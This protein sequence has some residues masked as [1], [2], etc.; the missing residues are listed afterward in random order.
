MLGIP[1]TGAAAFDIEHFVPE[2]RLAC[3]HTI[4]ERFSLGYNVGIV[5][6]GS[7]T[8]YTGLYS[9]ALGV[10]LTEMF[11]AYAELYGD[12][13]AYVAPVHRVDAGTTYL[14]TPDLQLDLSAGY[15]LTTP[16]RSFLRDESEYYFAA[17]CS[18]RIRMWR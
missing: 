8:N 1:G 4:S 13:A 16:S 9:V 2:A 10:S 15:T 6:N 11:G 3:S 14:A 7:L 5:L 17:G 12:L 18:W